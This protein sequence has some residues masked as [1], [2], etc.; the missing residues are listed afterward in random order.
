MNYANFIADSVIFLRFM[1]HSSLIL[2]IRSLLI[3]LVHL[4]RMRY[5]KSACRISNFLYFAKIFEMEINMSYNTT[6]YYY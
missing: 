5:N 1:I 2:L 4:D 6:F 3:E